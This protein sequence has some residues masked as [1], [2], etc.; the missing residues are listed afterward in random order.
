[1]ARILNEQEA[2]ILYEFEYG[3]SDSSELG[4]RMG[5]MEVP[6]LIPRLPYERRDRFHTEGGDVLQRCIDSPAILMF[7]CCNSQDRVHQ[8]G[9]AGERPQ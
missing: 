2:R 5:A 6:A 9:W 1:M 8:A 4:E 3:G 7:P